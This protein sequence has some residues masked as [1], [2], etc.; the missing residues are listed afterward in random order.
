MNILKIV[1]VKLKK[2][3][4]EEFPAEVFLNLKSI[5]A[6]DRELKEL[7][8]DYGYFKSLPLIDQQ[9]VTVTSIYLTN[10]THKKGET[11]PLG[12]DFF[13][14]Y[15]IDYFACYDILVQALLECMTDN[16][17]TTEEEKK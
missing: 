11:R 1:D 17:P 9:D 3:N 4:G 14:N 12:A 7:N 5:K 2:Y 6:I 15:Q 8:P 10:I 13:D 16:K